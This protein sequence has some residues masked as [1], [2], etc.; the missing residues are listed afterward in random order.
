MTSENDTQIYYD[1]D[2]LLLDAFCTG[3]IGEAPSCPL[4]P[5]K[6]SPCGHRPNPQPDQKLCCKSTMAEALQLPSD[7]PR[8]APDPEL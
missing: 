6:F 7:Y 2:Q 5:E 8:P 3:C 4:P 1:P